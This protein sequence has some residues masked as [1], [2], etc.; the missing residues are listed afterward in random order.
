MAAR[1]VEI[2]KPDGTIE[3]VQGDNLVA[4][5]LNSLIVAI[6]SHG[7]P[8]LIAAFA[9]YGFA[10]MKFPGRRLLFI[11]VVALLVVPLA[12]RL[13]AHSEGLQCLAA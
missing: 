8:I 6:P 10:W 2:R 9:A 11:M 4:P 3:T 13:C 7:D 5:F 1:S 12:D